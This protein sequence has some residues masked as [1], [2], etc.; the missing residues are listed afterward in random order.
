MGE[1]PTHQ[2]DT[3][4]KN[5]TNR[6]SL[7]FPPT[8]CNN[9]LKT[10]THTKTYMQRCVTIFVSGI[11]ICGTLQKKTDNTYMLIKRSHVQWC[12][13]FSITNVNPFVMMIHE[14]S[15][16]INVPTARGIKQGSSSNRISYFVFA[17]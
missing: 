8:Q 12:I 5:Y 4:Q 10:H 1:W 6:K 13:S 2:T 15:T 16:T 11:G 3:M 7:S 17:L 9:C 14:Q